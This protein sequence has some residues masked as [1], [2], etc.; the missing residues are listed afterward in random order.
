M[1]EQRR[2]R[3]QQAT[4]GKTGAER[5]DVFHVVEFRHHLA[6]QAVDDVVEVH[7][8]AVVGIIGVEGLDISKARIDQGKD[9][10]HL[11]WTLIRQ[12]FD[13]AD[14]QQREMGNCHWRI[15]VVLCGSWAR[16]GLELTEP[17]TPVAPR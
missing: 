6:R 4:A 2:F 3:Y 14:G 15:P 16:T 8:G 13:A 12:L 9:M 1:N 7:D 10:R 5:Q 11:A 17:Y